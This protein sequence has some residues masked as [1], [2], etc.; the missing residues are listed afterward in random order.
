MHGLFIESVLRSFSNLLLNY[1][2]QVCIFEEM[3]EMPR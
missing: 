2:P 3:D 1:K